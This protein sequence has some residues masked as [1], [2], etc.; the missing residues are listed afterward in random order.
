ML[1]FEISRAFLRAKQPGG[2]SG[3]FQN[4]AKILVLRIVLMSL[5][6]YFV[7]I[8]KALFLQFLLLKKLFS[9]CIFHVASLHYWWGICIRRFEVGLLQCGWTINHQYHHLWYCSDIILERLSEASE[10]APPL[11]S[12]FLEPLSDWNSLN[13]I[14][15]FYTKSGSIYI[16]TQNYTLISRVNFRASIKCLNIAKENLLH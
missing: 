4:P 6:L 11:L 16:M 3:K 8:L 5:S 14:D 2:K 12:L 10:R 7:F 13:S 1:V 9:Q 15:S